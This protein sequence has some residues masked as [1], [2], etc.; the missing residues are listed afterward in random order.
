MENGIGEDDDELR[1]R[2]LLD[3]LYH[4]HRAI[5]A[6]VDVR[7]YHHWA[8]MDTLEYHKGYGIKYGLIKVDMET[9]EKTRTLRNSGKM[10]GE[11]AAANGITRGIVEK[12][13]PDWTPDSFPHGYNRIYGYLGK[14]GLF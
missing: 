8:T 4:M 7:A 14:E 5:S 12:Y 13:V 3:H 10:Y 6:G 2:F 11:I 9:K 1:P